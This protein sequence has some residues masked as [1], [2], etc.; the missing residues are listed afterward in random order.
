[1]PKYKVSGMYCDGII[2]TQLTISNKTYF[3]FAKRY[4]NKSTVPHLCPSSQA[5]SVP[6]VHQM[7]IQRTHFVFHFMKSYRFSDRL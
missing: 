4:Q 6:T 1:M 5:T 3:I 2:R 7:D